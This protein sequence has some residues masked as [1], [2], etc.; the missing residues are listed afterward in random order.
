MPPAT[1]EGASRARARRVVVVGGGPAGCEAALGAARRGASVVLFEREA[2]LGGAARLAGR[3]PYRAKWLDYADF[4]EAEIRA[5][6]R[7][8]VR[9]GTVAD[10]AAIARER[11][12]LVVI[13]TGATMA[14]GTTSAATLLTSYALFAR[15]DVPVWRAAVVLDDY[16]RW[17]GV[18]AVELLVGAGTAV[19]YVS[20]LGRIADQVSEESRDFLLPRLTRAGVRAVLGSDLGAVSLEG[21]DGVV[22]AGE[23]RS[24]EA[25]R[26]W[27]L[28]AIPVWRVGD[29]LAP[30]GMSLATREGWLAGVSVD[31]VEAA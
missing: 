14:T 18:N 1:R 3:A 10:P 6:P 29:A 17:D 9:A 23:L 15:P 11:P 22:V 2:A 21:I 24:E 25:S 8:E 27:D 26:S 28:G 19:T 13:A 5:T 12:D 31:P 7:I 20:R 16:G 30:R 4:L